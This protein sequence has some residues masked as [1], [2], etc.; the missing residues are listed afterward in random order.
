MTTQ[1]VAVMDQW[2][3]D[4]RRTSNYLSILGVFTD[5][6]VAEKLALK[7]E[8]VENA[9]MRGYEKMDG[10]YMQLYPKVDSMTIEEIQALDLFTLRADFF[11]AESGEY[12]MRQSGFEAGVYVALQDEPKGAKDERVNEFIQKLK[13]SQPSKKKKSKV[14]YD[15]DDE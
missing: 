6:L 14:V 8:I 5:R 11:G 4:Y 15:D 12:S 7:T 3:D 9:F 13:C 10:E 1:Y 2:D